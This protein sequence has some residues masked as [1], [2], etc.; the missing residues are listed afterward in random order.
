MKRKIILFIT[1]VLLAASVW[2][3]AAHRSSSDGPVYQ[4]KTAREWFAKLSEADESSAITAF[5]AMGSNGVPFLVHELQRTNSVL[6]RIYE[7]NYR[8]LPK[9][10]RKHLP[11][12]MRDDVRRYRV[13]RILANLPARCAIPDLIEMLNDGN[14][15]RESDVS[16]TL[17]SLVG[18]EDTNCIVP[19]I[20]SLRSTNYDVRL[21]AISLLELIGPDKRAI[22]AL[23]N[24][25]KGEKS[26]LR[27][28]TLEYLRHIDPKLAS[29]YE[30][31]GQRQP[32][33]TN[34]LSDLHEN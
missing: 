5:L 33:T 14:A 9:S 15:D 10:I 27:S 11:K 13:S 21:S 8:K 18:P 19:L 29:Q 4:G 6:H 26:S 32:A 2:L 7:G 17:G 30:I 34:S 22:P 23:T 20:N 1:G 31:S 12:P 24:L 16:Y 3:Y 28:E 25:L